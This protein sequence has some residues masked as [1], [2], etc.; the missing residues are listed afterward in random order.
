MASKYT[1]LKRL[2]TAQS[3]AADFTTAATNVQDLDVISWKIATASIT[4]NTGTFTFQVRDK[5]STSNQ[6][7]DWVD[8][9]F[10]PAATLAD[11]NTTLYCEAKIRAVEARLKFTAAGGTPNGTAQIWVNAA[12]LGA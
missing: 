8:L 12:R 10:S 9:D 5:D 6:F 4:D 7:G 2:A 1:A 3:L 11:A